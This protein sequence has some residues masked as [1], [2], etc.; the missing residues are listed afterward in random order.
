MLLDAGQYEAAAQEIEAAL[1]LSVRIDGEQSLPVA[2]VLQT[3]GA[4]LQNW[5]AD[6][7][8]AEEVTRREIA[9]RR[10]V[11]GEDALDLAYPLNNLA[12]CV[13]QQGRNAEAI[14]IFEE[15]IAIQRRWMGTRI[16]TSPRPSRISAGST[17]GSVSTSA[18]STSSTR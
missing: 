7:A 17:T 12:V 18:R 4:L 11:Q 8:G 6:Y 3:Q 15:A 10:A 14:P 16:P 1:E 2:M 5:K 9:I 13:M